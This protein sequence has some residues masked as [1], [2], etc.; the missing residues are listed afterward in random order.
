MKKLFVILIFVALAG[1]GGS[2]K[3]AA[4]SDTDIILYH[5]RYAA[6]FTIFAGAGKSSVIVIRNPW[7]GAR[8]TEIRLFLARGGETAPENFEGVVVEAPLK[9]VVCMSSSYIAFIDALGEIDAVKGVSGGR[10]I[11]NSTIR[12]RYASGTVRD[13]GYDGQMNYETLMALHPDLVLI[14]GIAGG[15]SQ[16]TAKLDELGVKYLYIGDYVEQSPLG[17]AEWLVAFGE[18]FDKRSQAEVI[19]E[20]I[21]ESYNTTKDMVEA[22]YAESVGTTKPV[23]MLNAPYRDT[24]YV[25]GDRSY[26]VRLVGDA[27]GEYACAGVDSEETRPISIES[28]YISAGRAQVWLNPGQAATMRD[29]RSLNPRFADVPAV[30]SG[31]VFNCTA[32]STTDGGSDFWESGAVRPDMVLKDMVKML[33]PDMLPDHELYYFRQMR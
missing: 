19:F 25:P 31:R 10:Y 2:K 17:K 30:V 16:L 24:W 4:I 22:C 7:Q 20:S 13:V 3:L 21:S 12:E 5:P 9:R 15:N 32:R 8:G 6:G 27:G 29:V 23:V 33:L 1:C 26:M 18:M 11:T 28:A 14:Y